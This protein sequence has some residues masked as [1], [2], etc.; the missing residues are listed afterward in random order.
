MSDPVILYDTCLGLNNVLDPRRIRFGLMD[1]PGA[2]EF[3]QLVNVAVDDRGL[4]SLREGE[5][6][7]V[8][9]SFSSVFCD[10]G[11]CFAVQERTSDAAIVKLNPDNTITGV[12]SPITKGATMA[13]GQVGSDTY[14][15]NGHENGVIRGGVS[16][17]WP[18]GVYKG[19][20]DYV[21]FS[22]APVASHIVFRPGGQVILA[23][24][25]TLWINHSPFQYGLFSK[26][27]GFIN[28]AST[29]TMAT[30]VD[31]GFFASDESNTWFFR[32][33]SW[34][35]YKQELVESAPALYG[36]ACIEK[37]DL[38]ILGLGAGYGKIWFSKKGICVG[39]DTGKF[40]NLS[41]A[42]VKLPKDI[43]RGASLVKD[44]T[45]ITTVY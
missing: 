3:A 23:E 10:E 16:S 31:A 36:S 26:H 4:I 24:G 13:W 22:Q 38:D 32:Q 21:E 37:V 2:V 8:T 1:Q 27:R 41:K 14:Y 28:L 25:S 11:D 18:V 29:V 39:T 35:G 7:L 19:P 44:T 33:N 43:V 17:A 9:G 5:D 30:S 45:I 12:R 6:I 15:S 40:H 42:N 20:Q 34:Y